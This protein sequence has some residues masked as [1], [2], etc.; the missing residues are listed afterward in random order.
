MRSYRSWLF[1]PLL[2]TFSACSRDKDIG[3]TGGGECATGTVSGTVTDASEWGIENG[4]PGDPQPYARVLAEDETGFSFES[5]AES[6]G[7][8]DLELNTGTWILSAGWDQ[9]C[10]GEEVEVEAGCEAAV[11]DLSVADCMGR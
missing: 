3:D 9:S 1:V 5:M 6:D 8:Y 2:V 7:T 4:D 11:V 10:Y